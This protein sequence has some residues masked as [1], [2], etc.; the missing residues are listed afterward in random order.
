[1]THDIPSRRDV[2]AG[3]AATTVLAG[4]PSAAQ[5][6]K[7]KIQLEATTREIEVNGKL[8]KRLAVVGPD[9]P[10]GLRLKRGDDFAVRLTNKLDTETLIHWHGLILPPS[11]DG[12]PGISAPAIPPG[13]SAEYDFPLVQAGTYWMHSHVGFQEQL[14]L[15]MPLILEDPDDP[16]S[17]LQEVVLFL[18]DFTFKDP[19]AILA[20]LRQGGMSAMGHAHGPAM[21]PHAHGMKM[22]GGTKMAEGMKMP[23]GMKMASGATMPGGMKMDGAGGMAGMQADLNDVDFDAYLANSRTLRDPQV[24]R[25][26]RNGKVRVR[27]INGSASTNFFI[28]AGGRGA[29]LIAVDGEPVQPIDD[30]VFPIAIA[31]RMDLL[32][33]VPAG[34]VVPI[35]AQR[36]GDTAQ[37]GLV[38]ASPGAAITRIPEQAANKAGAMGAELEMRLRTAAPLPARPIA[39]ELLSTLSGDMERYI[40]MMHGDVYPKNKPLVVTTGQRTAIRMRNETGMAHPMHLHGHV[41]QVVEIAGKALDGAVRDTVMVPPQSDMV[42]VFDANNPGNWAYHCHNL[43]HMEAGMFSYVAYVPAA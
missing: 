43:Y 4:L 31:Q 33:D 28:S 7:P 24:V 5:A 36:E 9:G 11:Q 1:M 10:E 26:E 23:E 35:L 2:V 37:T 3:L 34:A 22:D 42:V 6:R 29:R 8:V 16:L 18:E 21:K 15:A 13:G 20:T 39:S 32:V 17:D 12:V 19:H 40:W 38:L 27:I 41:F 30:T 25:V 14:G